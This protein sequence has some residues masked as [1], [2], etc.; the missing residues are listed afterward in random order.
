MTGAPEKVLRRAG[1]PFR[2]VYIHAAHH[3][4]FYP[5]VEVMTLKLLLDSQ[6]GRVLGAQA[7]GG[8]GVD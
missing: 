5:G 7:A 1:R 2:K 4:G 6:T 3:A 8:I